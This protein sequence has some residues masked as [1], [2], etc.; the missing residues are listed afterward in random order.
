[1]QVAAIIGFTVACYVGGY[2]CD[3]ITSHL[4]LR[5]HGVFVP[6]QRLVSLVP[7]C[8]IAPSGCI[9]IAFACAHH[10]HWAA[11]AVGFGMGKSSRR[12][13]Q[14]NRN[15]ANSDARP[16]LRQ[17]PSAPCTPRTLP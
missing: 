15:A 16:L 10:L 13:D 9:L 11:I 1:M 5:N 17:F 6:E 7:G 14:E 4:I 8:L 2:I 3:V 12:R